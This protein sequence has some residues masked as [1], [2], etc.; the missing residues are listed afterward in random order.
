MWLTW[1]K[2]TAVVD[3]FVILNFLFRISAKETNQ[4]RNLSTNIYEIC[5]I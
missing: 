5:F 1:I 3:E 2:V 4:I